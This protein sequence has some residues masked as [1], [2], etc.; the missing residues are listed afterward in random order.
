L[1]LDDTPATDH[2]PLGGDLSC[3]V[4]VVGGGI[5]GMTAALL[6]ARD[7]ASVCLLDQGRVGTGTT[8]HTTGKVT[9]QHH[10]TY[11]QVEKT[12]GRDG[13]ATYGAAMEAA[14]ERVAELVGEGIAC[15]F[16]RR[17]AYVFAA[18]PEERGLVERETEAARRAGL[19]AT[20]DEE[21]P[22]PFPTAGGMRF[23]GQAEFHARRYLLGLADRLEDAG[24]RT[25]ECTRAVQVEEGQPCVVHTTHGKVRCDHVV[26]GTLMP[27][28]DRGGHFARAFPSRSYVVT[29]RVERALPPASLINAVPPLRSIRSVPYRNEELLMVL[30]EDHHT[31]SGEATPERFEKLIAY[32][33]EHWGVRSV[34]HRWS[35]QDYSPGRR[36]SVHRP[37]HPGLPTGACRHG[38]QEVGAD[39]RHAGGH[40]D[41]RRHRRPPQPVGRPVQRHPCQAPGRG[42]TVPAGEHPG[43]PALHRRPRGLALAP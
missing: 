21:V 16:R 28:L 32:V 2:P 15:D 1:W 10:I 19:P 3:D 13:A 41:G 25:F 27:F 7:G 40:A 30:G 24:G 38:L 14:K 33:D 42:A 22:L 23:D 5:T 6:L 8:G 31:G 34:V 17:A 26:I 4:V 20:F 18:G 12:H 35:A 9:S 39:L 43:G 37:R 29:A 11:S 36:R